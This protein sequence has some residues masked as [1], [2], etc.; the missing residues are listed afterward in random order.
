MNDTVKVTKEDK[1]NDYSL[2][3]KGTLI[4]IFKPMNIELK[5]ELAEKIVEYEQKFCETCVVTDP[6]D[7]KL[8]SSKI[9]FATGCR[10]D[11]CLTD[12]AVVGTLINVRQPFVLGSA[13]TIEIKY[14]I[15]NSGEAAYLTQLKIK[16]PTNVTQ[17]SRIPS[18]CN[19]D[20]NVLEMM[21]C[22]LRSGRPLK[23]LESVD[24]TISLDAIRLD[25]SAFSVIAEVFCAG[26]EQR[27]AD[28][29]YVNDIQLTEFSDV[30]LD[31]LV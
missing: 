17:F 2:V 31:G 18:I 7:T 20:N 4:D 8:V 1:C 21:T 15:S 13:K 11:R 5:Y 16:I 30:E 24:I 23:N 3:V 28:N 29:I 27:P 25:G 9:V 10:G 12:L 19:Q 22:D 6:R 26:D 14:D